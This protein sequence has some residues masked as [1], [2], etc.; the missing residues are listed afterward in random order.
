MGRKLEAR[1][2]RL[3]AERLA[4]GSRLTGVRWVRWQ[5]GML[6]WHCD[7]CGE[8]K[9]FAEMARP[10]RCRGCSPVGGHQP[11]AGGAHALP[12]EQTI[13]DA[14]AEAKERARVQE[15]LTRRLMK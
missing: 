5:L 11:S 2:E 3:K 14:R 1:R 15:R 6:R 10:G 9:P 13:A 4:L 7:R 12:A 8:S